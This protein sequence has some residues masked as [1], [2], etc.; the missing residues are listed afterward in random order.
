MEAP[1]TQWVISVCFLL[2]LSKDMNI[3]RNPDI[4]A[5]VISLT[6]KAFDKLQA[7]VPYFLR[8]K[9][10]VATERRRKKHIQVAEE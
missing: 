1:L 9:L 4:V 10:I 6:E 5:M 8:K 2:G 3:L 7:K